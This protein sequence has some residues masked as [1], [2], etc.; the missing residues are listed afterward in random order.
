MVPQD[1]LDRRDRQK[2]SGRVGKNKG[3]LLAYEKFERNSQT[4][5]EGGKGS[6]SC[7]CLYARRAYTHGKLVTAN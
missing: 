6:N 3:D 1:I 7:V 5:R 4:G 2:R